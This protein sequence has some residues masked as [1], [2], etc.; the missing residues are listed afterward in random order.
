MRPPSTTTDHTQQTLAR[1]NECGRFWLFSNAAGHAEV[2]KNAV[3]ELG[4]DQVQGLTL[5]L[6]QKQLA[7]LSCSGGF[8][9][10]C[11][12]NEPVR[13]RSR[14]ESSQP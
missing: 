13:S 2:I 11:S 10:R 4:P 5:L 1:R 6:E 12:V 7:Y 3:E 9:P 8:S 14:P